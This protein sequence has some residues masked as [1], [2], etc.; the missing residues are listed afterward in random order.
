MKS[1]ARLRLTYVFV[2]S[3]IGLLSATAHVLRARGVA[4]QAA[5]APVVNIAGRQRMLS[6]RLAKAALIVKEAT[7]E[8]NAERAATYLSQLESARELW[9][10]SHHALLHGEGRLEL[11]HRNSTEIKRLFDKLEP[12]RQQILRSIEEVI[13]AAGE[14]GTWTDAD[15]RALAHLTDAADRYLPTMNDIVF[16]YEAEAQ[17]RVGGM[18]RLALAITGLTIALLLLCAVFIFEPVIR[19]VRKTTAAYNAQLEA[20][21]RSQGRIEFGTDGVIRGVNK[22]Y[23]RYLGYA[24]D[25]LIGQH[26]AVLLPDDINPVE[27]DI[28]WMKLRAGQFYLGEVRRKSKNGAVCHLQTSYNPVLGEDGA[29]DK[30]VSYASDVTG[31]KEAEVE[32]H[33]AMINLQKQSQRARDLAREAESANEAKSMF[34]A[35][36]SHEIRTPMNAI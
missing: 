9:R 33:L 28:Q 19:R 2:L 10:K 1:I 15:D 34:L 3:V 11:A 8:G 31:Q 32:L 17:S 20:I 29:V 35:N 6:Q 26:E 27:F 21:D 14:C 5:D 4:L 16:R 25:E 12:D 22:Q 30:V 13:N 23:L 24:R 7:L 18:Q 36:M